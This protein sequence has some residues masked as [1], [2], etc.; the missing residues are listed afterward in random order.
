MTGSGYATDVD[1]AAIL[2]QMLA[3][4]DGAESIVSLLKRYEEV[5]LP[6]T[7]ALVSHSK[8]VVSGLQSI[9]IH[10]VDR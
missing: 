9:R 4:R 5:R 8:K 10:V 3:D 7:R 1:D 6:Y 2:A